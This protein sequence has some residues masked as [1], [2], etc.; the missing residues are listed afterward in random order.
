[1]AV[2]HTFPALLDAD[3]A[4]SVLLVGAG[5]SAG[6]AP[7]VHDLANEINAKHAEVVAKLGVDPSPPPTGTNDFYDWAERAFNG[8]KAQLGLGDDAAKVRL[9]NSIGITTDPRYQRNV[10]TLGLR[11]HWARH[12]VAARFAREER[13]RAIWS[14]NWD[15]ILETALECVGLRVHP[16]PGTNLSSSL[17][18]NQWYFTWSPGDA[19]PPAGHTATVYVCKPHGCVRKIRS[20]NPLFIVTRSELRAL[21][22]RLQPAAEEIH[23]GLSHA[24]LLT[25]GWRAEED[26][27]CTNIEMLRNRGILLSMG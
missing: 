16:Q 20:N 22:P 10:A 6:I 23:V 15:C 12:R 9:A 11:K 25:A 8:L 17:P 4:A 7:S 19:S 18:W 1:M 13:W 14:L 27:I 2:P 24:P 21:T 26:Y 3:A 5:M